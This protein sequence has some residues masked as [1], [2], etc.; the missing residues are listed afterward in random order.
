MTQRLLSDDKRKARPTTPIAYE[1]AREAA[2]S[3]D[4]QVRRDLA[5]REDVRPEI[6]YYLA[7]DAA[8]G[9]RREVAANPATPAQAN[10]HLV[11]DGDDEVRCEL[12]RKIARLLPELSTAAQATVRELTIETLEALANDQ[13]PRVRAILSEELKHSLDAPRAVIRKLAADVEAAV[14]APVLEY[15][16]L[17]S[18]PDLIEI[19]TAGVALGAMPALAR[20]R[21]LAPEA[22]DAV[23]AS[24][25]VPA[26]AALLGNPSAQIREETLDRIIDSA[27]G[28][29][30]LHQPLVL[31]ADL[32]IR[33]IRRI[34]TFV[35]RA[36]VDRLLD[37]HD[38]DDGVMTEIRQAVEKRLRADP[39]TAGEDV[40]KAKEQVA[41]LAEAGRLDDEAVSAA[42]KAGRRHFVEHALAE[43]SG[44][45]VDV[46]HRVL[47][48][49][50]PKAVTALSWRAGLAMRT[51]IRLQMHVVKIPHDR[52]LN[53]R[54][55][56]VYPMTNDDMAWQLDFFID[57]D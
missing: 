55:G 26:V 9:V 24:M 50:S 53:A 38:L 6:L 48:S 15:S 22:A 23:V 19:I 54:D 44:L 1:A 46:V 43:L 49:K 34:A 25:E 21:D 45:A 29:E 56:V 35:A 18:D 30:S 4:V 47:E 28:V 36:L 32:S 41:E 17:L 57:T 27:A 37:R 16:P 7:E 31:R 8:P 3:K 2:R 20:R 12:A 39:A 14:A 10:R 40:T 13:L 51:A 52:V 42:A 11:D 33:A 5:G